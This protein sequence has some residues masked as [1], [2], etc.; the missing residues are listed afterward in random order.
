[1]LL[2]T[3]SSYVFRTLLIHLQGVH[4]LFLYK[5]LP[6]NISLSCIVEERVGYF[7]LD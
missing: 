1:M 4:L 3:F 7:R 6:N 2:K 5:H